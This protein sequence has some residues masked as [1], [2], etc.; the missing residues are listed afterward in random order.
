MLNCLEDNELVVYCPHCLSLAIRVID[1]DDTTLDYCDECG[2]TNID[3]ID[4][5]TWEKM[6]EE[7]YGH[8]YLII[9]KK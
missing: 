2:N 5:S 1:R 7:K 4:F 9:N 3:T 6:Y 8:K